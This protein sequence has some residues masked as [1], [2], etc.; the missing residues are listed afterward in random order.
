MG[1]KLRAWRH[2]DSNTLNYNA[3]LFNLAIFQFINFET[4]NQGNRV[5]V[6]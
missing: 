3:V 2:E 1:Y 5:E 6:A 4:K